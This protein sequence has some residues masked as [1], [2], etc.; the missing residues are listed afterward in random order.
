LSRLSLILLAYGTVSLVLTVMV[1]KQIIYVT[2]DVAFSFWTY[3]LLVFN[4]FPFLYRSA[5]VL[6]HGPSVW[7]DS[8]TMGI[9]LFIYP[10]VVMTISLALFLSRWVFKR[11][12]HILTLTNRGSSP[13]TGLSGALAR[14][15]NFEKGGSDRLFRD[16]R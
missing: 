5:L 6:Q 16:K 11:R 1:Y 3:V 14:M 13:G 12:P 2:I 9:I 4:P 15:I 8:A 7:I 10:I